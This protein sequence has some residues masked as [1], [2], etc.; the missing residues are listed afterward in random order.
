[1]FTFWRVSIRI[2]LIMRLNNSFSSWLPRQVFI[3]SLQGSLDSC[4]ILTT[5]TFYIFF[6]LILVFFTSLSASHFGICT[7][8]HGDHLMLEGS[9]RLSF[10]VD[11]CWILIRKI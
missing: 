7:V 6:P 3:C 9:R 5:V 4:Q 11:I 10:K 8:T 2:L 1:M